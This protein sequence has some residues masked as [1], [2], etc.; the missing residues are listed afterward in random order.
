[1][2]KVVSTNPYTM[3]AVAAAS[4][5][6]GP[7][8]AWLYQAGNIDLFGSAYLLNV[9]VVVAIALAGVA[10]GAYAFTRG[11]RTLGVA[12]VVVNAGVVALYGFLAVFFGLGGSR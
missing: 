11:A 9:W 5:V 7:C 2:R 8:G 6:L 10:I 12:S 3:H 4:T 1:M